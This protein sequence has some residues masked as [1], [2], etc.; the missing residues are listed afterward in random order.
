MC[1][2]QAIP[3]QEDFLHDG[4]REEISQVGLCCSINLHTLPAEIEEPHISE[5]MLQGEVSLL[6]LPQSMRIF[7]LASHDFSK[8]Y[9][10]NSAL[11]RGFERPHFGGKWKKVKFTC[12]DDKEVD[13]RVRVSH[14]MC[15]TRYGD[16]LGF[17]CDFIQFLFRVSLF[18][19]IY[20]LFFG[21]TKYKLLNE[22]VK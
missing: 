14:R 21:G 20:F 7:H 1:T 4:Y 22:Y 15:P 6:N 11:P 8:I 9:V 3:L 16:M 10:Q 12:L 5:A 19:L 18:T 17:M 2:S 13:T